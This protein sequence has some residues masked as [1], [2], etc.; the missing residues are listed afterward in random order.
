M[1]AKEYAKDLKDN[2]YDFDSVDKAIKGLLGEINSLAKM[3]SVGTLAGFGRVVIE[4]R[5]K[6][7]AVSKRSEGHL[8]KDGFDKYLISRKLLNQDCSFNT[9]LFNHEIK[10]G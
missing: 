3:R 4:I 7:V 10:T 1:K 5:Q 9:E 6:W 8:N 2:N